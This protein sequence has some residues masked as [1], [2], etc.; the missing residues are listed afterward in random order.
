MSAV[1]ALPRPGVRLSLGAYRSV[2][3]QALSILAGLIAWEFF[4]QVLQLAWL[5]PFSAVLVK[6]SMLWNGGRIQPPLRESLT[7]LALGYTI[8]VVFGVGLG[9]L[10]VIFPKL[11]Y[12]LRPYVDALM[13]APSIVLAPVLFVFLGLSRWL[14]ISV[15]IVYALVYI[16]ANTYIAVSEVDSE[17]IAMA[18]SYGASRWQTFRE[19]ILRASGPMLFAG[20]RLGLGRAVKG[21]I[22][23]ELIITVI[24]LG[25]LN[26]EF[27]GTF[28]IP[29]VLAI[30]LIVVIVALISTAV[31]QVVD[32]RVNAWAH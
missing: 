22:N 18:R 1:L 29:G 27:E 15:I 28:D 7:N 14:P 20:L 12:M 19:V 21:M 10:M 9:T 23:G 17:L 11:N 26:Q 4:G 6:L 30:V 16:I 8:C 2:W 5:P 13:L 24:G 25:A 31:L 3:T 32:R